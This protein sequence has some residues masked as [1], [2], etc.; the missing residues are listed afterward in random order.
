MVCDINFY[1]STKFL[2]N[3]VFLNITLKRPN[4]HCLDQA[5]N[6][7][8]SGVMVGVTSIKRPFRMQDASNVLTLS[9]LAIIWSV[10]WSW[11]Q[12]RMDI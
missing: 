7:G 5:I 2:D 3:E 8:K 12:L 11:S 1:N 10:I 6:R 9:G 4:G